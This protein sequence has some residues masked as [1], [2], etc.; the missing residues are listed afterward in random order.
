M[1]KPES[2]K[3]ELLAQQYSLLRGEILMLLTSFKSQ[4]QYLQIIAAAAVSVVG[5][6]IPTG[7]NA[8]RDFWIVLMFVMT[9]I[10]GYMVFTLLETLY[11]VMVLSGTT[12]ALED[13]INQL[14]NDTLFIWES[15]V[16][17]TF[18]SPKGLRPGGYFA[19]YQWLTISVGLFGIPTYYVY[20]FAANGFCAF[21]WSWSLVGLNLI[22]G[23]ASMAFIFRVW[24]YILVRDRLRASARD[25]SRRH[26][27]PT[28][29]SDSTDHER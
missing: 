28:R 10:V 11:S 20:N 19:I 29:N 24:R 5:F 12:S 1:A 7:L 6:T 2:S 22:Y 26:L 18:Y 17:S 14:A 27:Q 25:A 8:N 9:T 13:R 16:A 21:I 15:K 23:F 3:I 4:T